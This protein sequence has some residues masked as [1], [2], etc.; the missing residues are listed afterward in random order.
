MGANNTSA[1][2]DQNDSVLKNNSILSPNSSS[3]NEQNSAFLN[4]NETHLNHIKLQIHEIERSIRQ[5]QIESNNLM[6]KNH[7]NSNVLTQK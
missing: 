7:S 5:V 1:K 6:E 3:P 2:S 4:I